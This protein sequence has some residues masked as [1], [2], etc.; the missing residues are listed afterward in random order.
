MPTSGGSGRRLRPVPRP[1]A[2]TGSTRFARARLERG[3]TQS[4]VA[5][6]AGVSI[7]TVRRLDS[8]SADNP[9]VRVL[10]N[11]AIALGVALEDIIEDAW[12]EPYRL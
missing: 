10:G 5:E 9:S 12:R 3:L 7:A 8:G 6:A 2:T 4:Q 1:G 11:C